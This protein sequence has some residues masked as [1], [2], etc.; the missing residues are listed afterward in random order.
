MMCKPVK[1]G[2]NSSNQSSRSPRTNLFTPSSTFTKRCRVHKFKCNLCSSSF[3]NFCKLNEHIKTEHTPI[4]CKTCGTILKNK[5]YYRRHMEYHKK[6]FKCNICDKRFSRKDLLEQHRL[7]ELNIRN[8]R[9]FCGKAFTTEK[10]LIQHRQM[11][12]RKKNICKD[13]GKTF[14]RKSSLQAHKNVV[15]LGQRAKECCS[16]CGKEFAWKSGL[17]KH[18]RTLHKL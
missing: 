2:Q 3:L 11:H 6:K 4:P 7:K 15:H 9:C 8:F 5:I 12:S 1:H 16:I 10:N 14:T 17:A 18:L 13:C